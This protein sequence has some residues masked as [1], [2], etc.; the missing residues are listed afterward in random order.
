MQ[1][2]LDHLTPASFDE[3]DSEIKG[4]FRRV[5]F[6]KFLG[7][8]WRL[9]T[10]VLGEIMCA[11]VC[12]QWEVGAASATGC[13]CDDSWVPTDGAPTPPPPPP[14]PGPSW[15]FWGGSNSCYLQ[16]VA[17]KD[18]TDIWLN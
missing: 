5:F 17:K 2:L 16:Q 14:A 1:E 15:K 3:P 6:S 13:N 10:Y 12:S 8:I 18:K 7:N 4:R 11:V 9:F